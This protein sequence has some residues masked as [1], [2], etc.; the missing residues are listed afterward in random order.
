VLRESPGIEVA[1]LTDIGRKRKHNEDA[2]GFFSLSKDEVLAIVADGMGD[3]LPESGK[4][5]GGGDYSGGLFER[6][7]GA[8]CL[9]GFEI[10]LLKS[11]I[12]PSFKSLWSKTI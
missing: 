1:H 8:G 4:P 12:L 7:N 9:R 10:G 6:T 3:T 5:D 11:P 2:F